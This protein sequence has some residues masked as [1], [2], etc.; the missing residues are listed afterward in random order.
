M[1]HPTKISLY[2]ALGLVVRTIAGLKTTASDF[3]VY[4]FSQSE[5]D[6]EDPQVY[7][8]EPDITIRAIGKWSTKGD[9]ASDYNFDQIDRYHDHGVKF[10]GSGTASVIFP[11]DF[12]SQEVFDDMSTKDANGDPV[13]HDEFGFEEPARRG[14]VFNPAYRKYLLSWAKIQVDGGVDGVNFDEWNAGFSGGKKYNFNGNEGF[15]DYAIADFTSYLLEKYSNFTAEDWLSKFDAALDQDFNYRSYLQAHGWDD[16]PL[17]TANPLAAEWGRVTANRMY[18]DDSSFTATYLRRY[19]KEVVDEL[20]SYAVKTV[21]HDILI[22]SNGLIPYVDFNSV[23]MY[24]WN[25][26]EQTPDYRGADYVPVSDGRLEGSKSLQ[27]NYRYFKDQSALI[28]GPD[29]PVAV[30]IDWPSDMMN[31]YLNLPLEDKKD[32]W[33]IFGAEAY[34]NGLF[35]AFHLKDTVGSPSAQ[36]QGVLDFLVEYSSFYKEHAELFVRNHPVHDDLVISD[37]IAASLLEQ[38]DSGRLTIHLVNHKYDG[39]I[40]PV[41]DLELSVSVSKCPGRIEAVSPDGEVEAGIVSC[42][43]GKLAVVV[44]R[45]EYYA[46]LSLLS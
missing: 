36:E 41:T 38:T 23:G 25:P 42:S 44:G 12:E 17:T 24:P 29:V 33:R 7:E 45:L 43:G 3:V 34:A 32:Y 14:N 2:V 10:M 8:L 19:W 30:F 18:A 26:D 39:G 22:S 28:S 46:V 9:E 37:G 20:R 6:L 11:K 5:V 4:G 1:A 21:G 31:D 40:S 27:K 16:D 13:P 35:P 15:D